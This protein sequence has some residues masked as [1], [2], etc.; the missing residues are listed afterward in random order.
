MLIPNFGLIFVG[1]L[2][3]LMDDNTDDDPHCPQWDGADICDDL[4]RLIERYHGWTRCEICGNNYSIAKTEC[5]W[6]DLHEPPTM[7][8]RYREIVAGHGLDLDDADENGDIGC[9]LHHA[10][11]WD[12]SRIVLVERNVRSSQVWI[13]LHGD[14]D[15]AADGHFN[16]EYAEE[17]DLALLYDLE[18]EVEYDIE[19]KAVAVAKAK[20]STP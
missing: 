18:N 7:E 17:W 8:A 20:V 10:D 4:A 9:A 19:H 2:A 3:T 14:P 11:R 6:P 1:Q 15:A 16:Q 12:G 13:T 5:P